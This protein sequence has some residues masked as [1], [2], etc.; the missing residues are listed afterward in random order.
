[1]LLATLNTTS[2]ASV[3]ENLTFLG[4]RRFPPFAVLCRMRPP[5]PS[6]FLSAILK[7]VRTLSLP[8]HPLFRARTTDS[9]LKTTPVCV[10]CFCPVK[11][12]SMLT[13]RL[14]ST[15]NA[16]P[17]CDPISLISHAIPPTKVSHNANNLRC[18][19]K[20]RKLLILNHKSRTIISVEPVQPSQRPQTPGLR[21]KFAM[22]RK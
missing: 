19:I 12:V 4:E 3:H 20:H 8:T 5:P 13:V 11:L 2:R 6:S 22:R 21:M 18:P 7:K 16:V 17:I 9:A 10:P 14:S 1:M 15:S